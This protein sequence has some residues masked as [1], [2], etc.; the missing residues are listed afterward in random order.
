MKMDVDTMNAIYEMARDIYHGKADLNICQAKA[1]AS[2]GVNAGSFI[3]YVRLFRH[4]FNGETYKRDASLALKKLYIERIYKEYGMAGLRN[5]LESY[6][7]AIQYYEQRGT[8]KPGDRKI[9]ERY[10]KI[11]H[12]GSKENPFI[13]RKLERNPA[14]DNLEVQVFNAAGQCVYSGSASAV[15]VRQRPL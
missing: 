7:S 3:D 5:A 8:N 14:K 1:S 12:G 6:K 2:Y 15:S 9:Y 4:M 11:L 13:N 10:S